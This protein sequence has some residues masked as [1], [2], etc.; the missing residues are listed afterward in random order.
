[1]ARGLNNPVEGVFC[2]HN[3]KIKN[4]ADIKNLPQVVKFEL[5]TEWM[6]Y[7]TTKGLGVLHTG[8]KMDGCFMSMMVLPR[9]EALIDLF[10]DW[11]NIQE[12]AKLHNNSSYVHAKSLKFIKALILFGERLASIY[13]I[14]AQRRQQKKNKLN[15]D[16]IA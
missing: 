2:K 16:K 5:V 10:N 8:N 6:R 11:A 15:M 4:E 7:E 13:F 1:M 14:Q 3:I 9:F 12:L